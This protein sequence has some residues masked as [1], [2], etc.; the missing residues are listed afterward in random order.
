MTV[1]VHLRWATDLRLSPGE[2]AVSRRVLIHLIFWDVED[3]LRIDRDKLVLVEQ[4]SVEDDTPTPL[5]L[6]K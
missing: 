5:A 4:Q 3:F 1:E 2:V 6:L